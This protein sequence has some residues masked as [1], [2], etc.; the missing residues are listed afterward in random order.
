M[1]SRYP[2][3]F[4]GRRAVDDSFDVCT[5]RRQ[6]G[7]KVEGHSTS[8]GETYIPVRRF[9]IISI[10]SMEELYNLKIRSFLSYF[11]I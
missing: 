4:L 11:S 10:W 7:G 6:G 3:F 2:T 1:R 8:D 9:G 5:I